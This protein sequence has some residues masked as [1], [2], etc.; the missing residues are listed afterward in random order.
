V[1]DELYTLLLEADV[2]VDPRKYGDL[3]A[4]ALGLTKV[5]AR[6][7]V[8]RGRGIFAEN[9]PRAEAERIVSEL[10]KDRIA[11]RMFAR[12][13]MPALP[14]FRKSMS[15]SHGED[16]LSYVPAGQTETEALPWEA[17][18]VASLG[19]VAKPEYKELFA[20]VPFAMIPPMHKLEG[21]ERE[22]VRENL[23]LKMALPPSPDSRKNR[24]PDSIF[25]A[26]DEKYGAKVK[27]YADLV[28]ADLGTWLRIPLDEMGYVYREGG[29]KMGGAWGFQL[30]AN[31]LRD[32]C[33]GALSEMTLK[34]LGASDIK[35][36]VFPQVEEFT[37]YTSW[38]ALKRHLWPTAGTSSPS[39]EPPEPPTD[40][41]SSNASSG[42]EPPSISS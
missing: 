20:H 30:L 29:V 31:D 35:E 32:K 40:A 19:V 13:E 27:V 9:L 39:P 14:A 11:V 37:R 6:M 16:L 25:E 42:A 41:G 15:L 36:L 12:S 22:V 3:V 5:E 23:I 8:R 10:E 33:P 28:T 26:I 38:V 7:A 34:L 17:L 4:P 1:S 21:G 24:I 2:A 18:L